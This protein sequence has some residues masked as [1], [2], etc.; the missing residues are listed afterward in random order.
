MSFFS[1]QVWR[2]RVCRRSDASARR[3]MTESVCV[4]NM[5]VGGVLV[6]LCGVCVWG[7]GGVGDSL[8]QGKGVAF[9]LSPIHSPLHSL[10]RPV[11]SLI[12]SL[13]MK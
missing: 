7:R 8:C 1:F 3:F 4:E 9:G 10:H 5:L 6:C 11:P 13:F 12:T 2:E